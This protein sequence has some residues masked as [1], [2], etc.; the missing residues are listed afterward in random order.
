MYYHTV[1]EGRA[2]YVNR[3]LGI[4]ATVSYDAE[5]LPVL[6]EWKS[7]AQ[8]DYALGLEPA[9][10]RFDTFKKTVIV[11]RETHTYSVSINFEN[12]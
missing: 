6:L 11:P 8:D 10:T 5:K 3:R 7:M 2:Q 1:R 9:S 4:A 12:I